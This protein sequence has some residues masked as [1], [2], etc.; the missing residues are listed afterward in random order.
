MPVLRAHI[1]GMLTGTNPIADRLAIAAAVSDDMIAASSLYLDYYRSA[2]IVDRKRGI[3]FFEHARNHLVRALH[4]LFPWAVNPPDEAL[5][6]IER[7]KQRFGEP[8]DPRTRAEI[9][10]QIAFLKGIAANAQRKGRAK[11]GTGAAEEPDWTDPGL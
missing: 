10:R 8:D 3:E 9:E 5:S 1:R 2:G 6:M 4:A 7:W 11:G